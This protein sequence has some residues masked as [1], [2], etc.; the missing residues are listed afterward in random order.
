LKLPWNG[1][2]LMRHDNKLP[3]YLNPKVVFITV[4][5]YHDKLPR[6][7]YSIGPRW[8]LTKCHGTQTLTALTAKFFDKNVKNQNDPNQSDHF[9]FQPL[10]TRRLGRKAQRRD[11]KQNDTFP[12]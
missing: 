12:Q 5:I 4:V 1:G 10:L 6:Q 7:F 2:K 9:C 3:Q 8:L 11:F